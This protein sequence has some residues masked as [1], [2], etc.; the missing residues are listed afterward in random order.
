MRFLVELIIKQYL[1][2]GQRTVRPPDIIENAIACAKD[3]SPESR[4]LVKCGTENKFSYFST[5]Y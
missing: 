4:P 5:K 1:S 2:L 3:M